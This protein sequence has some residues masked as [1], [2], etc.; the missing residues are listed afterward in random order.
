[1]DTWT[2]IADDEILN[3][4]LRIFIKDSPASNELCFS[5][6]QLCESLVFWICAEMEKKID[7]IENY[8]AVP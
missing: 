4:A 2:V 1:M 6:S 5:P 7:K 3:Y 8:R